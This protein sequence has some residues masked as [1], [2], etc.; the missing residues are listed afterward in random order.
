MVT[1]IMNAFPKVL[2]VSFINSCCFEKG[3]Y[4]EAEPLCQR[5]LAINE[6]QLGA[7]H[8]DTAS[9]LH[10]LADLYL[11][12]G[13]YEQAEVFYQRTLVIREQR[14]G[15]THPDTQSTRKAYA[16][17]LRLVGRDTEATMLD[18]SHRPSAEG[19]H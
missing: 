16:T 9:S 8:P 13:K 7:D 3:K 12:Q 10:G 18:I 4:A 15:P 17:F 14:L 2:Q 1:I 11:E 6:Q 19:G 5:A